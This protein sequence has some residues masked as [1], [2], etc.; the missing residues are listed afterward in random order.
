ML[1]SYDPTELRWRGICSE[2]CFDLSQPSQLLWRKEDIRIC[3]PLSLL[4]LMVLKYVNFLIFNIF[5]VIFYLYCLAY[6]QSVAFLVKIESRKVSSSNSNGMQ[7]TR[8]KRCISIF[9][10]LR[11]GKVK[12][13]Y[14]KH[15]TK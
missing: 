13:N 7:A 8:A 2:L 11:T 4:W 12:K 15:F 1:K 10:F 14:R 9:F 3:N 5:Y 6:G